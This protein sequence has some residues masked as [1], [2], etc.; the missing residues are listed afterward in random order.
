MDSEINVLKKYII[1]FLTQYS[2]EHSLLGASQSASFPGQNITYDRLSWAVK[3][4]LI[5]E[6]FAQVDSVYTHMSGY[7]IL[8][9]ETD[10]STRH[11]KYFLWND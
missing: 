4:K 8:Y 7:W 5:A 10:Y 6:N 3:C 2:I 1:I 11:L 9:P